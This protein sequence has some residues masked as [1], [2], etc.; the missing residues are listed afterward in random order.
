MISRQWR[1]LARRSEADRYVAHLRS[2]TFPQ[3]S[4]IPGFVEASILR[5][6][7]PEGVEFL[8][9]TRWHSLDSIRAFA[10]ED[11]ERAVVPEKVQAMMVRFD[12]TVAHY[13]VVQ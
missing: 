2:E 1:G 12:A 10:G 13:E 3:L 8:I 11:V 5:R 9:V 4:G 7:L 6:N